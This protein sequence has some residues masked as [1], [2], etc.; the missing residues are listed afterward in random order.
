[1]RPYHPRHSTRGAL[2]RY[3]A[4][5]FCVSG[6][7]PDEVIYVE[8][9]CI[10]ELL[11]AAMDFAEPYKEVGVI[12]LSVKSL[13]AFARHAWRICDLSQLP[14]HLSCRHGHTQ[15]ALCISEIKEDAYKEEI[16]FG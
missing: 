7:Q 9:G 16:L 11:Q 15:Y 14:A 12:G 13:T 1:M 4:I 2:M 8:C 3:F 5:S 6:Y 10:A